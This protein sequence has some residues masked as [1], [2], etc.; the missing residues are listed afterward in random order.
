M[1]TKKEQKKFIISVFVKQRV[2]GRVSPALSA[3]YGSIQH[4]QD[5]LMI[6]LNIWGTSIAAFRLAKIKQL[7]F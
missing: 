7:I 5:S 4:A 2:G 1:P 3:L 6:S